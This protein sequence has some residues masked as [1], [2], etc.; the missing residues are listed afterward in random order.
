MKTFRGF[1]FLVG[2][3]FCSALTVKAAE[4]Q[5]SDGAASDLF[6]NSVSLSGSMGLA[7]ARY[8][9]DKGSASGSAYLY[10]NLNTASGTVTQQ[11]K[12]VASDGATDDRFGWSVSLSG[13]MGLAGALED[14]DN[15]S[16]SGSAYLFR[17]LDTASGTVSEDVK[18]LASDGVRGDWFG[19]STSLSG[20]TGL[21]GAPYDA[22]NDHNTGAAYLYRNLDTA[23]GTVTEKAK[24]LASDGATYDDFGRFVSLSG[25]M[26]L[27]S[28][29][30]DY[31]GDHSGSVYLFRNLDTATGTVTEN[32]KLIASD[33]GAVDHF[34]SSVSL[35]GT[36]G[37]VGAI[38]DDDN[39]DH[40]GSAYLY[41]NLDT[42][43]GTVTEDIKLLASDGAAS[44]V[45]GYS[46]SLSG[47][48]GLVGA[49]GDD[50]N[51]ESSGAAY[52][53]RNLDTVSGTVTED[54]KLLAS[55]GV[56]GDSFGD[57]VSLDG[58]RFVVGAL[59][60]DGAVARSGKAYS[61][62][63][64][65]VTTL[66]D[67]SASETI[68]GIS[69]VSR[70]DWV[71][72]ET[73]DNNSV[74]LSDGDAADVTSSGKAVYIGKEETSDL[75]ELFLAGALTAT[76]V[77]IGTLDGEG[78]QGN[79]LWL[80]A[81]ADTSGVDE[82]YLSLDNSLKIEDDYSDVGDLLTYLDGTDLQLWDGSAWAAL[83]TDN[84]DELISTGYESGYTTVT[85][86]PEPATGSLI[87]LVGG[88]GFL[89]RR[90]FMD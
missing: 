49:N 48:V 28:A 75:N 65:S 56:G 1:G 66:D 3:V 83:T 15:G 59:N 39:G 77:H 31:N 73:T 22:D 69:F 64:K 35:S 36:V 51:G 19:M 32:A 58:D 85:A 40:S 27:V 54:V 45:F 44:D 18:L 70:T 60:G 25:S 89:L 79:L 87:A 14:D 7:G 13:S 16:D 37:L 46:V 42:A 5:A 2:M 24:L 34:S 67:G 47:S 38:F 33:G 55:D 74:T 4:L 61:G 23:T 81:T 84:A 88:I 72:G 43:S 30:A 57:S 17:N 62:S 9:D 68:S 8:D 12:L 50:D 21:V 29:L 82:F 6:G 80:A 10:R 26:G 76:A 11:V 20:S 78:N 41:R 63:V 53:Y 71:I 52:L 90:R 86:I